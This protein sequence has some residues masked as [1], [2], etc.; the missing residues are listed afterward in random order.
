MKNLFLIGIL[1]TLL[2]ASGCRKDCVDP[3]DPECSNY[4]PCTG[5]VAAD[6]GFRMLTI[7]PGGY[8]WNCDGKGARNLEF[9]VDTIFGGTVIFRA[10]QKDTA[11]LSYK[12]SVGADTRTWTTR[13]FE[14]GFNQSHLGDVSITLIVEKANPLACGGYAYNRDSVTKSLYIEKWPTDF[15]NEHWSLILGTWEGYNEDNPGYRYEI[16]VVSRPFPRWPLLNNLLSSCIDKENMEV[17]LGR[18]N[19]LFNG[20]TIPDCKRMCGIGLLQPDY[21]TLIIEYTYLDEASGERVSRKFIGQRV[22]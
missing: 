4:D 11:G 21:K 1:F 7:P 18:N 2:A 15:E 19:M 9:D 5:Y 13:E 3:A 12:W 20:G 22:E 8:N 16:E 17:V 10:N 14:L 6:A